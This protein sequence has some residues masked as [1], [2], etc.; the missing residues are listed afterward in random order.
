MN[1]SAESHW[2]PDPADKRLLVD[3]TIGK[4]LDAAVAR[5]PDREAIVYSAYDDLG[6]SLRWTYREFRSRALRAAKAII[7]A[8]IGHGERLA[9]WA[10]NLPQWLELQFGAAYVGVIIVPMNPLFKSREVE[11]VLAKSGAVACVVVPEH[12][13]ADLRAQLADAVGGVP[14]PVTRIVMVGA[15]DQGALGL[16]DWLERGA[17]VGDAELAARSHGV[18]SSDTAQIQFTSGT[19]GTP[20]GVELSHHGVVNDASLFA[21]RAKMVAG[22]RH[23]NP[24]PY[25]H[26]GGSIMATLGPIAVGGTQLPIITF[27]AERVI[28]TIDSES[29]TSVSLVPTMMIAIEEALERSGGNLTSLDVVVTG[30]SPVP[31]ALADRWFTRFGTLFSITYGLTETSPVITQTSPDDPIDLQIGTCGVALPG[32]EIDIVDPAT[33]H[34]LPIGEQ[35]EL[36]VRGWPVMK[37]YWDNPD[38]T[39]AAISPDGFLRTGDLARM[40]SSGYVSITGRAKEMIIRG[41]EN[42][43]PAEVEN[44]LRELPEVLD[45]A[46]IGVPS[47]RYGEE[48]VAFVRLVPGETLTSEEMIERLRSLIARY[49]IPSQLRCVDEFPM[50]PSGKI[51]K[52][53]LREEFAKGGGTSQAT[54]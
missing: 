2:T 29:A 6:I 52:F 39:A 53:V 40:A 31:P 19:T 30:G 13:G 37:G 18:V 36:R 17:E 32:V 4:L 11:F 8:G 51:Q 21:R 38:A 43:Y 48:S 49:K 45:A 1:D 33:L 14:Q 50:T 35:G 28:R 24:M 23:V 7:A 41:G 25:F 54:R 15:P 10:P 44:V 46:V 12:R 27:D 47:E 16:E 26:C 20:K 22:G 9:I 34:R 5:H 42:I 3:L